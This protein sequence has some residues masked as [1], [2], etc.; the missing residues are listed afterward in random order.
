MFDPF[1]G[2]KTDGVVPICRRS[3][4][5]VVMYILQRKLVFI[6]Q[7]NHFQFISGG[8]IRNN[9]FKIAKILS[10]NRIQRRFRKPG[11]R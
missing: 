5:R 7:A 11:F 3:Q 6:I 10:S 1:T 2:C 4:W 8:I 9:Y